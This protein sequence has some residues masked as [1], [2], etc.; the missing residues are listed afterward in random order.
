M[1]K[2]GDVG[3]ARFRHLRR[4]FVRRDRGGRGAAHPAAGAA[5][6]GAAR[7]AQG[8][9]WWRHLVD[10]G[11]FFCFLPPAP[12]VQDCDPFG[13]A[14]PQDLGRECGFE[15]C[16]RKVRMRSC[17][18]PGSREFHS[19]SPVPAGIMSKGK[20][21]DLSRTDLESSSSEPGFSIISTRVMENLNA[22]TRGDSHGPW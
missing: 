20:V 6:S 17:L 22:T 21:L 19:H 5:R 9:V 12:S 15:T 11:K 18:A 3:F 2:P 4:G 7:Q 10:L 16:R 13:I 14:E 8:L 1:A